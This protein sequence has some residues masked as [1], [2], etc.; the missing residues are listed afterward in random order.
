MP[1]S[2]TVLETLIE[3]TA[4]RLEAYYGAGQADETMR[5]VGPLGVDVL[6][7]REG[8]LPYVEINLRRTMGHVALAAGRTFSPDEAPR[9]LRLGAHGWDLA[10]VAATDV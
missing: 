4:A 6:G 5:Y 7:A 2:E 9:L 10:D 1:L 8:W 3:R